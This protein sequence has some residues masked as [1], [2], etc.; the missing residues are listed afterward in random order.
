MSANG[1]VTVTSSPGTAGTDSGTRL[2]CT[3]STVKDSLENVRL[4]VARNLAAGAD[5]LFIFLDDA[6]H[7]VGNYLDGHDHVTAVR[8]GKGYWGGHRPR[9]LNVRQVVNANI[10]NTLLAPFE[11]VRWLFHIDGDE[12]LDVDRSALMNL[13]DTARAVRLTTL[14]AVSQVNWDQPVEQFKCPLGKDDLRLLAVL[15]VLD[16]ADMRQYYNGHLSG[17]PGLRPGINLSL[18]IHNVRDHEGK[19]PESVTG[20]LFNIL[21]YESFS[22]AEFLRKWSAHLSGGREARVNARK[23]QL[24]SAIAAVLHN[25]HLEEQRKRDL[26]LQIYRR[27]VEDDVATLAEL[28]FLRSPSPAHHSHQPTGLPA[29]VEGPLSRLLELLLADEAPRVD[30]GPSGQRE[31]LG[32]VR[33]G[34][35]TG[36]VNLAERLD[37]P[38]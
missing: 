13:P 11:E 14:E 5:H 1:D 26:L 3:V 16:R 25:T 24:R 23:A 37:R 17:K 19:A 6:D 34:L 8:T 4:F 15:G 27:H 20:E 38:R 29:E 35:G 30:H 21:H 36:D 12:C 22:S 31:L 32:R 2:V 28:G 9:N 33:A 10:V 18:R 7:E